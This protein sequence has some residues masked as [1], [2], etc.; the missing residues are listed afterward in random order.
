MTASDGTP[1]KRQLVELTLREKE[2]STAPGLIRRMIDDLRH[3]LPE[4]LSAA[5]SSGQNWMRG[6]SDQEVA[7]AREI[8]SQTIDRIGRLALDAQE[9]E[10]RQEMER[11]QRRIEN[12]ARE[13]DAYLTAIERAIRI[14]HDLSKA[15][16][17]VEITALLTGV[18][19]RPGLAASPDSRN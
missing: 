12:N 17:E 14:K 13:V 18:P 10:H 15:G 6:K 7:K 3:A 4:L 8:M 16:I 1:D 19:G 11:D 5:S 9:Q 2:G